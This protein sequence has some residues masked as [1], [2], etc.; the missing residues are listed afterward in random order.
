MAMIYL[1]GACLAGFELVRTLSYRARV[2]G[3]LRAATDECPL[4]VEH[5]PRSLKAFA[6]ETR[7]LGVSLELPQLQVED[8]LGQMFDKGESLDASLQASSRALAD[9][10]A[11]LGQ[12]SEADGLLLQDLGVEPERVRQWIEVE[13]WKLDRRDGR[14]SLRARLKRISDE[15]TD[16]EGCLQVQLDPY[17]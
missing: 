5:L 8:T 12:L 10:A 6:R 4:H 13:G 17:R 3:Y 11:I 1:L 15:L 7:T 2:R 9:W 14:A 16:F